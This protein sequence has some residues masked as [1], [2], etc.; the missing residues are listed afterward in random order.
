MGTCAKCGKEV[1]F[2][3]VRPD[4][5]EKK[6]EKVAGADLCALS[7]PSNP[8]GPMSD[9]AGITFPSKMLADGYE[10]ILGDVAVHR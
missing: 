3:W 8:T 5:S 6:L 9:E 7:A 4:A 10:H 2:R 1:E